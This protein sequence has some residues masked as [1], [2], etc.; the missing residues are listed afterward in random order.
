MPGL[1]FNMTELVLKI[2]EIVLALTGFVLNMTGLI[3]NTLF[4]YG[5]LAFD[6]EVAGSS[7]TDGVWSWS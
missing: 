3:L 1:V 4:G 5:I 6:Q 7:P 2:T